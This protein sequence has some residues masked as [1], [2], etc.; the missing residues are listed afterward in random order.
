[1]GSVAFVHAASLAAWFWEKPPEPEPEPEPMV[2]GLW[3]VAFLSIPHIFYLWLWTQPSA[4]ISVS[5]TITRALGGAWSSHGTSA[6]TSKRLYSVTEATARPRRSEPEAM[7]KQTT[8]R[9][10]PRQGAGSVGDG[11]LSAAGW[12]SPMPYRKSSWQRRS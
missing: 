4:W 10:P 1:M 5:G 6:R 9:Q 8:E 7:S 3:L 2:Q 11:A 12:R